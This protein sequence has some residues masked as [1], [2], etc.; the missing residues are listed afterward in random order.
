MTEPFFPNKASFLLEQEFRLRTFAERVSE[1]ER[2]EL[3]SIFSACTRSFSATTFRTEENII[4][5]CQ[6]GCE[7]SFPRPVPMVKLALI[8]F[9]YEEWLQHKYCLP[10]FVEVRPG[11][12]VVDCGAYVGGFSLSAAKIAAQLHAFEPDR[13]NA[14]CAKR[15]LAGHKHVRVHECG[16]YDRSDEMILNVSA[17]SVE[18]SLLLPDDGC[19]IETR[20]I[21]VISLGDFARANGIDRYDFVKIEA[22]GVELEVFAGLGDMR[23]HQ[24]AIDVSPERDGKSPAEE[25]RERLEPLGYEVRQRGDV[26]FARLCGSGA[27]K[28]TWG[29]FRSRPPSPWRE[30]ATDVFQQVRDPVEPHPAEAPSASSG[31]GTFQPRHPFYRRIGRR[32]L[33]LIRPLALPFLARLQARIS[34][35]VDAS[36]SAQVLRQ[37][38]SAQQAINARL[39]L[40]TLNANR[41][42]DEDYSQAGEGTCLSLS[43]SLPSETV[44]SNNSKDTD[45]AQG[46]VGARQDQ[47]ALK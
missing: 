2:L 30:Y 9:G 16:L 12:V 40:L 41:S 26:M 4:V 29:F 21:P 31:L 24:L 10:G 7:I 19:V 34:S 17:N 27:K 5:A 35:G 8:V 43:A 11:D 25:F 22:E 37:I 6:N 20:R 23:P 38:L 47:R 36:A 3:Y 15:N 44:R 28:I 32:C 33:R 1:L 46:A 14:A 45:A 42:T 18:H 13:G 39:D